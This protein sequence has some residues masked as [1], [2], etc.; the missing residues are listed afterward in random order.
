VSLRAKKIVVVAVIGAVILLANA[1]LVA[2]WLD[3][4]GAV[5]WAQHVRAEYFTGTAIVVILAMIFLLGGESAIR[6]CGRLVRRCP[7]C[8]HAILR[9]GKYC[10][11]CG[12]RVM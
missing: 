8:D 3:K 6:A 4:L 11:A 1:W 7:V 5:D 12:S 9:P 10:G 2:E